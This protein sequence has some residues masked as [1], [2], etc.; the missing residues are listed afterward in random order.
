MLT[1]ILKH[2]VESRSTKGQKKHHGYMRRQAVC[3]VYAL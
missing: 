2:I 1:I 3:E